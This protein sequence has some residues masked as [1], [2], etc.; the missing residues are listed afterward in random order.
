MYLAGRPGEVVS[1]DALLD[2]VWGARE[3]SES[4]L[5]RT[6]TELRHALGDDAA[7]PRFIETIPKRGT[8]S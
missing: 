6:V 7:K 8:D 2:D 3:I 1:K 4:A 5:T